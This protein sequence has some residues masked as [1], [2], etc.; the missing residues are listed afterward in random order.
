MIHH[1]TIF[2]KQPMDI[3]QV[4][5]PQQSQPYPSLS[6][7]QVRSCTV[8]ECMI[9]PPTSAAVP[10][11]RARLPA[12]IVRLERREQEDVAAMG[13]REVA[14]E[15]WCCCGCGCEIFTSIFGAC[16]WSF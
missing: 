7:A 16:F 9:L 4:P 8:A 14:S 15:S 10:I 5:L 12:D 13:D 3:P 11:V 1:F 6:M 2:P